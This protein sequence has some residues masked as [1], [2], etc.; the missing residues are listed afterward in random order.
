MASLKQQL[1]ERL[2]YLDQ[3]T[4]ERVVA[5]LLDA[6]DRPTLLMV[7]QGARVLEDE[8][9]NVHRRHLTRLGDRD[10]VEVVFSR[11]V[12]AGRNGA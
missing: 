1:R 6:L 9:Y 11:M 8:H 7:D 3:A 5:D 2:D 10:L 12:D 4:R